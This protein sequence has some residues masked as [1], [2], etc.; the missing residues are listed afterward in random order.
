M[1][2]DGARQNGRVAQGGAGRR[3][4]IGWLLGLLAGVLV[5]GVA[6]AGAD[7]PPPPGFV[8]VVVL[9]VALTATARVT[10]PHALRQWDRRGPT[11]AL[12][13]SALTGAAAGAALAEL[14]GAVSGGEPSV[15]VDLS[16]R[17]VGASVA[18]ALGGAAAVLL[19]V[20]AH[21]WDRADTSGR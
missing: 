18:A 6:L 16:A 11:V 4:R 8:W 3:G 19:V 7:R 20:L 10:L 14:A 21:Q 5:V 15:D 2:G 13:G 1:R 9:A 12:T 17:L